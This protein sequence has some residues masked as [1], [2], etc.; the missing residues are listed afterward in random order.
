MRG[1]LILVPQRPSHFLLQNDLFLK[2]SIYM[3]TSTQTYG[4]LISKLI[5]EMLI[6]CVVSCASIH[7]GVVDINRTRSYNYYS[8]IFFNSILA[9]Y[10]V[11]QQDL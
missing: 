8:V 11:K 10:N 4:G 3:H 5:D 1:G 7:I 9:I 6:K 2:V